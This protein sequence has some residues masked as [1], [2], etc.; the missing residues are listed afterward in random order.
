MIELV[1]SLFGM[2]PTVEAATLSPNPVY[3]ALKSV[4]TNLSDKDKGRV[5][6]AIWNCS[7]QHS[8]RWT[9][10]LGIAKVESNL[11]PKSVRKVEGRWVDHGLFQINVLSIKH[12][13]FDKAKILDPLY[14]T[15]AACKVIGEIKKVRS[16][17][18]G[19]YNVGPNSKRD[20]ARLAYESK[21][22]KQSNLF[23]EFD[24]TIYGQEVALNGL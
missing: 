2:I 14:N 15:Q 23:L 20:K 12:F 1:L 4:K 21:V 18:I 16:N 22:K 6:N 24:L 5:A 9:D 17:W 11:N 13:K 3:N 8:I 19:Y 7:K 10:M